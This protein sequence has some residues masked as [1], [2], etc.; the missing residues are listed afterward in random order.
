[1]DSKFQQGNLCIFGSTVIFLISGAA[2]FP[3]S[4]RKPMDLP[5]TE[6][7]LRF[8]VLTISLSV[9]EAAHAWAAFRLGDDTAARMGRLTLNPLVHMDPVGSLMILTG[10]PLGWAKPV[11]VNPSRVRSPRFGLPFIAF[12]G[13]L[14]NIILGI[15]AAIVYGIMLRQ[16]IS[17]GL[18][19]FLSFFIFMNFGL[20]IFNLLPLAPLDGSKV[21]SLFLPPRLAFRYDAFIDRVGFWPLLILFL[22]EMLPGAGPL[23][24]WFG[25]WMPLLQPVLGI[26]GDPRYW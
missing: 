19:L 6:L 5:L 16:G 15:I 11:P 24:L 1:M 13:P 18:N 23:S 21:V 3:S 10:M 9:H 25:F 20:A 4:L 12:A 8:F 14:S 22:M 7:L 26:F 2:F 17:R